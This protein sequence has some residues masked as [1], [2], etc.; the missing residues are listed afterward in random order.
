MW[1]LLTHVLTLHF[2]NQSTYSQG[3]KAFVWEGQKVSNADIV[4]K[5][6]SSSKMLIFDSSQA[7]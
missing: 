2:L 7:K 4:L 5:L 1:L 6:D 3:V